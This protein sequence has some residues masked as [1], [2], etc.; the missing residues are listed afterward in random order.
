MAET[1]ARN[2]SNDTPLRGKYRIN[3]YSPITFIYYCWQWVVLMKPLICMCLWVSTCVCL[4][5][6][7]LSSSTLPPVF[8]NQSCPLE[9]YNLICE[10]CCPQ[11]RHFASVNNITAALSYKVRY[12]INVWVKKHLR[13]TSFSLSCV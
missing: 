8:C 10:G 4:Y 13:K 11:P 2:R 7:I 9:S 3:K 1:L 5:I 6:F 12:F